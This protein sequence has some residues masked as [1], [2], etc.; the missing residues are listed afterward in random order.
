[1]RGGIEE[2]TMKRLIVGVVLAILSMA[3]HAERASALSAAECA[4]LSIHVKALPEASS[5]RCGSEKFG[6][7]GD[8]GFGR[9]EFIQIMGA[10]SVFI[11]SHAAAEGHTY[12]K[13]LGVKDVIGNYDAFE[14]TSNWGDETESGNFAVRRFDAKFAG[15]GAAVACFGFVH[16]AGHVAGA[17]GYRHIISGFSCNFSATPPTD[18][19]IDELMGSIDYGFE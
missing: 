19:R 16:F 4:E 17:T 14:S 5:A 3:L 11:V 2:A 13:R 9:Q 1:M 18:A 6:G 10:D 12:M 8:Q 7:G 15:S